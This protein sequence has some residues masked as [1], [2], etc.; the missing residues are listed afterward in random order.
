MLSAII[1]PD[2]GFGVPLT[3]AE[4]LQL[5]A[6][7]HHN[8]YE[9]KDQPDRLWKGGDYLGL[10]FFD[11]GAKRDGYWNCDKM[12]KQLEHFIKGYDILFPS[13]QLM[14]Q[15]DHSS[16]HTKYSD[17]ALAV[18]HMNMKYGGKQR[19]PRDS[20]LSAECLGP[21]TVYTS[22]TANG[23]M[24]TYHRLSIGDT[25][26]FVFKEGDLPPFDSP[27]APKYDIPMTTQQKNKLIVKLNAERA[28]KKKPFLSQKEIDET[29]TPAVVGYIGK[30]KGVRHILVERGLW[31]SGMRSALSNK[32]VEQGKILEAARDAHLALNKCPDFKLEKPAIQMLLEQYGHLLL[33]SPKCHPELAGEGVEYCIGNVKMFYR[34]LFN[35]T[36]ADELKVNVLKAVSTVNAGKITIWHY[37]RRCRGYMRLY[38]EQNLQLVKR[39]T[40]GNI[41]DDCLHQLPQYDEL[42]RMM[43]R[44]STHRNM[45]ELERYYIQRTAFDHGQVLPKD[46]E[47]KMNAS[48]KLAASKAKAVSGISAAPCT[49]V[50]GESNTAQEQQP[51]EVQ[52]RSSSKRNRGNTISSRTNKK[53]RSTNG[54]S[55]V[56]LKRSRDGGDL[57]A[58]MDTMRSSTT[59]QQRNKQQRSLEGDK[60]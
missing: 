59:E 31:V 9:F 12:A 46:M 27:N 43:K 60:P 37:A 58:M 52:K 5:N 20:V 41:T 48:T 6:A 14:M 19:V 1:L 45:E 47:S 42:E 34:R 32:D 21:T 7:G 28:K 36:V 56:S 44:K 51:Q 39:D 40:N 3:D 23:T 8:A 25:Q 57:D 35:T 4:A 38:R 22:Q 16:G 26:S 54:Q 18:S 50:E 55:G 17:D 49:N 24:L 13:N 33:L 10:Q 15:L 53:S 29:N 2:K 11:F 30:P